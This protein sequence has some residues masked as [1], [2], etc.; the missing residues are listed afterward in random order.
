MGTEIGSKPLIGDTTRAAMTANENKSN[1]ESQPQRASD[2][3][4]RWQ[5]ITIEHLG[6]TINLFLTFGIAALG[7]CF[8]LLKD[9]DFLPGTSARCVMVFA[10]MTLALSLI[11]GVFCTLNRLADFRGTAQRSRKNPGA[12]SQEEQRTVG[13]T[14]WCLLY[15]QVITVTLGLILLALV[16]L[17]TYGYKLK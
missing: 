4:Q 10:L 3:F 15:I 17:L 8:A 5:K 12:P 7:Y 11:S 2:K 9:K 13:V 1:E 16:M 14:T 6:Y